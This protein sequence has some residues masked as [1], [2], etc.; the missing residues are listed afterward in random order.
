MRT[1]W[2][3]SFLL[4]LFGCADNKYDV[5]DMPVYTGETV[6]VTLCLTVA[7]EVDATP[8]TTKAVAAK[9]TR[10]VYDNG[11][12][13]Q[14]KNVW[15]LQFNGTAES[16][17]LI[18]VPTYVSD[19]NGAGTEVKL[20]P[21]TAPGTLFFLANTFDPDLSWSG[22]MTIADLKKKVKNL[23]QEADVHGKD[24]TTLKEGQSYPN[25][26]DYYL[27]MNGSIQT[28]VTSGSVL[29][30]CTLRRNAARID[31]HLKNSSTGS[32]A[33]T[34]NSVQLCAVPSSGF[35]FTNY[36]LPALFPATETLATIDYSKQ[37]YG[38]NDGSDKVFRCYMPVNM[39]GEVDNNSSSQ[40]NMLAPPRSTY[41]LVS[42]TYK[43]EEVDIPITYTF[44]LGKD[45]IKD[46]NLCP[47]NT[48]TYN[49]EIKGKGDAFVDTRV[50]DWGTVNYALSS[51]ERA[52]CYI[53]NP[54]HVD[55]Y[56]RKFKI[57]VDRVNEFWGNKG[58]ENVPNNTIGT[59][60]GW[61]AEVLWSDFSLTNSNFRLSKATGT[62][63]ES[64]K[65]GYFEVE[66][67]QGVKGN[68]VIRVHRN[69]NLTTLWSWHLWIT[70]YAP[71]DK[72]RRNIIP[73]SGKYT[74][75]V[76]GGEVHRYAGGAWETGT[77]KDKFIMDRDLGE[78]SADNPEGT[79]TYMG[80]LYYQFG[81]KDPF[82]AVADMH[83]YPAGINGDLKRKVQVA[84]D[85]Q[86]VQQSVFYPCCFFSTANPNTAW[87]VGDK[88]N[89]LLYNSNIIWQDPNATAGNGKKSIFDP[90][91]PGWCTPAS[92][93]WSDFN[94]NTFAFNSISRIYTPSG[95]SSVVASYKLEGRLYHSG[96]IERAYA[97][98][99]GNEA[100]SVHLGRVIM[101]STTAV[102]A[103]SYMGQSFGGK[104]RAIQR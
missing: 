54:P 90:S 73:V 39:R 48:Y 18:G 72:F 58:Y 69:D 74:Y 96:L 75:A 99:W 79:Q 38:E 56:W 93:V 76:N 35:Y 27:M 19:Y 68:V 26:A 82:C 77:F 67:P 61:T 6:K 84:G 85:L 15:V 28:V 101:F 81:R 65:D 103:S 64:N 12:N 9:E 94:L 21:T 30:A 91:P 104:V 22:G 59:A 31:F 44:Y 51:M 57:P 98:R 86:N 40:K 11:V 83:Y 50:Q 97:V 46:F 20:I 53:L 49:I 78:L 5:P 34:I 10:T 17:T 92:S 8:S 87:T 41:V 7:A 2:I 89:P 80:A 24:N 14:I 88:Y 52:N 43:E 55:K 95:T 36:N 63:S 70:D 33:V 1:G 100:T 4:L 102:N 32:D 62:G 29:E 25:D 37:E 66:I 47:N 60:T 3:L 23:S 42:A 45:L 71:D 13:D 16:S